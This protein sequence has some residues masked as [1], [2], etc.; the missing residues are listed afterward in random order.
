MSTAPNQSAHN[1]SFAACLNDIKPVLTRNAAEVEKTRRLTDENVALLN[2]S[3]LFSML[4]PKRL[5]GGGATLSEF[6]IVSEELGKACPSTAWVHMILSVGSWIASVLPEAMQ[7]ELF[8]DGVP[9]VAGVGMPCGVAKPV[10]GGYRLSGRWPYGTGSLHAHWATLVAR[11][12]NARGEIVSGGMLVVPMSS[13]TIEDTWHIAG[14]GGTGSQ[15]L[16]LDDVFV[17]M[18]RVVIMTPEFMSQIPAP[19][20]QLETSDHWHQWAT[21]IFGALGPVTGMAAGILDAVVANANK[22]AIPYTRYQHQSDSAN[23]QRDLAES[24]LQIDAV[25]LI[26]ASLGATL[27]QLAAQ[28]Q[29]VS[30]A[31]RARIRGYAGFAPTQLRQAVD[32]LLN[33]SGASSFA[34]ANMIQRNWRDL[35]VMTRHGFMVPQVA[36]EIYGMELLGIEPNISQEF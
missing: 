17:P 1:V 2:D 16:A 15:T 27:D 33:I 32:R 3:G 28:K 12:E 11:I 21:M 25:R 13:V 29:E 23:F 9:R 26:K 8:A 7:Q 22:R 31:D 34:N 19:R 20:Y 24:A 6:T 4:V 36:Y 18:N 14:M 30:R 10:D 5:G 35:S